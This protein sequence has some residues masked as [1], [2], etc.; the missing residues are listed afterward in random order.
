MAG[1]LNIVIWYAGIN[2]TEDI[3][4]RTAA[5]DIKVY[6]GWH[7]LL[8]SEYELARSLKRVSYFNLRYTVNYEM[9][10][11]KLNCILISE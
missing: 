1:L 10:Y 8:F 3:L 2:A 7:H 11:V 9:K 6:C 4:P 5:V